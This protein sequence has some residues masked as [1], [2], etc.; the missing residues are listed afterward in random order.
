L[1]PCRVVGRPDFTARE[2]AVVREA[3]AIVA[4]LVGGPLG[5]Y[6]D[7]SPAELAPRARQVLRFLLE[8]DGDKQIVARLGISPHTVNQ[9]TKEIYKH[10]G[11][12]AR[13]ELLARWVRRGWGGG[14]AW[15]DG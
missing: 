4:P 10:F 1:R 7:A 5:R 6:Q 9:H 14:F 3:A 8:G 2:K 12:R 15:A 11:V 13:P